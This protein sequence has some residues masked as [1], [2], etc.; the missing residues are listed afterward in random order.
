MPREAR[1][2]LYVLAVSIVLTAVLFTRCC[3]HLLGPV[4]ILLIVPYILGGLFSA[5]AHPSLEA[6]GFALGLALELG[7]AWWLLRAAMVYVRHLQR[8]G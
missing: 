5:A 7:F 6:M 4:A 3:G 1:Q 2:W 8:P